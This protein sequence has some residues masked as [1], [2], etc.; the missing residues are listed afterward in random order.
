MGPTTAGLAEATL[1]ALGPR[2]LTADGVDLLKV[3]YF[4]LREAG[5]DDEAKLPADHVIAP[6]ALQR[7]IVLAYRDR[8]GGAVAS[9]ADIAR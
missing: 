1:A 5:V 8:N 7:A 2:R 9:F 3:N 4:Y 6:A